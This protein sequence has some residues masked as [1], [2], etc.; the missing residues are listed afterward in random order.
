MAGY[1]SSIGHPWILD[2]LFK[3][4]MANVKHKPVPAQ[5]VEFVK[6]PHSPSEDSQCPAAVVHISDRK[7]YIR[8]IITMEAKE[9]L[10]REDEHFTLADIKNKIIIL[11]DFT[12]RFTEVEDLKNCEFYLRV[13]HF[14]ILPMETNTVD[15]LNCNMDP[16]VRKKIKELWQNYMAELAAKDASPDM[17]SSDVSLTQLLAIV[18]EEKLSTLTSLAEQCL[19]LQ[20]AAPQD[21]PQAI[22]KWGAERKKHKG[23]NTNTFSVPLN[24]LLIPP[25]EE[26]AL[27][28]ITEFRIDI[29]VTSDT[30]DPLDDVHTNKELSQ[31]S[32]STAMSSMCE[33]P[34]DHI[35]AAQGENPWNNLQSLCLSVSSSSASQTKAS[36]PVAH[37]S[38]DEEV[39][40]DPDS[41][42]PDLSMSLLAVPTI[43]SVPESQDEIS[44]LIFSDRSQHSDTSAI[45]EPA[46][47]PDG[48]M[49]KN[50]TSW[51]EASGNHT[52]LTNDQTR[53][54]S[55]ASS[56]ALKL[57]PLNKSSLCSLSPNR[58]QSSPRSRLSSGSR[59]Q[60]SPIVRSGSERCLVFPA[61]DS[62]EEHESN[63]KY[64]MRK[65]KATKRKYVSE[66]SDT[67]LSDVDNVEEL[68]EPARGGVGEQ[69]ESDNNQFSE[70]NNAPVPDTEVEKEQG[71]QDGVD[72]EPD[73]EGPK[74]CGG[75]LSKKR[76]VR[77]KPS[78]E[79]VMKE[80]LPKSKVSEE[81]LSATERATTS[82]AN[83][84]E[85]SAPAA[86]RQSPT[87][88]A[89]EKNTLLVIEPNRAKEMRHYDGSLFQYKYKPPS[90]DLCAR[91]NAIRLP[92]EFYEWSLKILSEPEE[93]AL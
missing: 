89:K 26:A 19:D 58:L 69:K 10:E 66:D 14:S 8:G 45:Q 3:Y 85:V 65:Q 63:R 12:V 90:P 40:A 32:P 30:K 72:K 11:K 67:T 16:T 77:H 24:L 46:E 51:G 2:V 41:S 88:Q 28:Q 52:D 34:S 33:E 44:P 27:D 56:T 73:V 20:L 68:A 80:K 31:I 60:L 57:L 71:K 38:S 35:P 75:G 86:Q 6:M 82:R 47:D 61:K 70:E 59:V 74:V 1:R 84:A 54:K 53:R 64:E 7:Y 37:Q 93:D 48:I 78:L 87:W 5:V 49:C 43:Q 92:K 29:D 55:D 36:C 13:Q 62:Q 39:I 50:V 9:A 91:V 42:T 21:A 23:K 17:N 4:E 76:P 18:G 83:L 15:L 25:D 81:M 22:T 79:F